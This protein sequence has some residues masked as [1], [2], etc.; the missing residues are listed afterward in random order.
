[1]APST[2]LIKKFIALLALATVTAFAGPA[3]ASPAGGARPDLAEATGV[4]GSARSADIGAQAASWHHR[5]LTAQTGSPRMSG[6][7][8]GFSVAGTDS[9]SITRTRRRRM[10]TNSPTTG[11]RGTGGISRWPPVRRPYIGG[12]PGSR[13]VEWS[14]G[15]TSTT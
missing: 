13:G 3:A 12:W 6:D 1:M 2:G 5:D 4:S 9:G 7:I 14:L 8:V 15:S 10:F 11:A